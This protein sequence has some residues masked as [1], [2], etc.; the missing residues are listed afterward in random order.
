M[1]HKRLDL[2]SSDCEECSAFVQWVFDVG[3]GDI[4]GH[5]TGGEDSGSWITIPEDLVLHPTSSNVDAAIQSVYDSFFFSYTSADYLAQ[6]SIV[7]PTN[8]VDEINDSVFELALGSFRGTS[9]V[10]LYLNQLIMFLILI[11]S[12]LLSFSTL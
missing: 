11:L 8:T 12:I 9:D 4:L 2:S 3:N 5:S 6:R 1:C 7:C 10:T